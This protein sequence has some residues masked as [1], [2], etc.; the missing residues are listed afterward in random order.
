MPGSHIQLEIHK[1]HFESASKLIAFLQNLFLT[2]QHA[3]GLAAAATANGMS[4]LEALKAQSQRPMVSPVGRSPI[5]THAG[6]I[7]SMNGNVN[8]SATTKSGKDKVSVLF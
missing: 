1:S 2:T 6:L 3:N 4:N 5:P 7:A 8:G